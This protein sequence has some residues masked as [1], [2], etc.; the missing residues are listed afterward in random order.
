MENRT[1]LITGASGFTGRHAVSFFLEKGWRVVGTYRDDRL[2]DSKYPTLAAGLIMQDTTDQAKPEEFMAKKV[3]LGEKQAVFQLVDQVR[4][5]A[6]L[7][8]AAQNAV[9]PSWENPL[10]TIEANAIGT[11]HLLEAIRRHAPAS[12]CVVVGSALEVEPADGWPPHPYSFSKTVQSYV[13]RAWSHLFGLD[14]VVARPSNL[15]G[16]GNSAGV[17]SI[18]AKKIAAMER[19]EMEPQLFVSNGAI[20]RDFLDVRDAVKAYQY[21]IEK[22]RKTEVY[23]VRSGTLTSL[24]VVIEELKQFT[25]ADFL[26]ED[27]GSEIREQV[28]QIE[29][30]SI[31]TLG[32]KPEIPL[33]QSLQDTLEFYRRNG[34]EMNG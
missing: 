17:C 16:P 13:A 12:K 31:C 23:D 20:K 25:S 6:V 28:V 10:G 30:T 21:L 8:L 29:P 32:W 2:V 15:I 3:D 7:H 18:F 27:H 34:G 1:I 14:I 26:I 33:T 19:G 5:D 22:G 9:Q 11:L 24:A 4:P